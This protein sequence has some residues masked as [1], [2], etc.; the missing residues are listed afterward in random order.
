MY[1]ALNNEAVKACQPVGQMAFMHKDFAIRYINQC[2]ADEDKRL[3][4]EL[5]VSITGFL[6]IEVFY[7]FSDAIPARDYHVKFPY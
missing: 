7:F 4:D 1:S 6:T 3:S 2:L 5:M